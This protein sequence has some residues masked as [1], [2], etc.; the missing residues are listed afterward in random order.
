VAAPVSGAPASVE[1][2]PFLLAHEAEDDAGFFTKFGGIVG[3]LVRAHGKNPEAREALERIMA[4][5][6]AE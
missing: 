4:L 1:L 6:G 3:R 2:E 5:K